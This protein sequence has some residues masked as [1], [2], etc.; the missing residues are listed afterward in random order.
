M[1]PIL[2][3]EHLSISFTRYGRWLSRVELDRKSVV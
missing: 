3:V 2:T 1:E